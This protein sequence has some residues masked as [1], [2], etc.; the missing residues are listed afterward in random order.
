[1]AIKTLG[2]L[3][4]GSQT[5]A[6]YLKELNR[7]FNENKGGYST[8]PF[9]LFNTNFDAINS[10]LPY[11]SDDLDKAVQACISEIE[12]TDIEH[13]IIPNITLHET[14][15]RIKYKNTILHPVD[16]CISKIKENKWSQVVLFGSL[17]TMQSNYIRT[18]FSPNNI[19]ILLPSEE[20]RLFIDKVRIAVYSDTQTEELLNRY[21]LTIE[22]YAAI[23]PI[24]LACT[25][26]SIFKPINK[27][28]LDMA[29]LQIVEAVKTV[30]ENQ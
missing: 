8:C 29:Q 25:E 21:H 10:L 9:L 20:D 17:H 18:K 13:L 16:I 4:L 1:M 26:L 19:E 23:N 28:L 14:I 3:G 27:N 12:N 5:T 30:L 7:V 24:I 11:V 6:F 15:D 22:K 2:I